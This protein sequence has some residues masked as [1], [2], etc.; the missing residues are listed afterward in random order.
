MGGLLNLFRRSKRLRI[1]V[2][3]ALAL[4]GAVAVAAS[5]LVSGEPADTV[6]EFEEDYE[7]VT[8][9]YGTFER[10]IPVDGGLVF[11]NRQALT[12]EASGVVGDVTVSEGQPVEEG[13]VLATF[14]PLVVAQIEKSVAAQQLNMQA[15]QGQLDALAIP[16][17]VSVAQAE[18]AVV[19]AE[20]RADSAREAIEDLLDAQGV[21]VS[22]AQKK[23]A[24]AKVEVDSAQDAYDD[25][26]DGSFPPEV[27]RDARNRVT[28]AQTNL[29]NASKSLNDAQLLWDN[30]LKR[31]QNNYDDVSE[32]YID[33]FRYW[34]G[35]TP[36]EEE[37]GQEPELLFQDWGLDLDREFSRNN[38]TY[39]GGKPVPDD[40]DTRWN[41]SIIWAWLNIYPGQQSIIGTC[42]DDQLVSGTKRCLER[43][44]ED[45]F[46]VYDE[47]R[48]NWETVQN[49]ATTAIAS[50]QDAV[51]AAEAGLAD[52]Q[53]DLLDV[54]DGPDAS[55]IEDAD[56]RLQLGIASLEQAEDDLL[57]LTAGEDSL[58]VVQA[59]TRLMMAEAS[60]AEAKV[61]L[62]SA[63]ALHERQI[64]VA[65]SDVSLAAAS[66]ED[67]QEDL[68]GAVVR[69]PFNGIVSL[70]NVKVDDA[71]TDDSRVVEVVDPSIIE[72]QG[73]ID[74]ASRQFAQVGSSADVSVQALQGH[75][76]QGAVTFIAP[77][78]RTERGVVT[79]AVR[80]RADVP[81]NVNLPLGLTGVSAVILGE[82][83]NALLVPRDAVS[84]NTGQA[85]VRVM[86]D[87]AV[88]DQPVVLGDT[89]GSWTVVRS[90]L[91]AGDQ[92]VVETDA[93]AAQQGQ[94][95]QMP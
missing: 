56:K 86:R 16:N 71:V 79:Y 62:E 63:R 80:I 55:Q 26:K 75:T 35:V 22:A 4:V 14:D 30:N 2:P 91:T 21:A 76:L 9:R 1:G 3:V 78:P 24:A 36:T 51:T 47:A 59:R 31:A 40:P 77:E 84:R 73:T 44:F 69:A 45:L 61:R 58:E 17:P 38:A 65:Q 18:T 37:L 41:E 88:H 93:L 10:Q 92:V 83:T 74:A 19:E 89:N 53:E 72:V 70:V 5:I 54:E 95:A 8:A 25:I 81:Q 52:A 82:E 29:D 57:E 6:T 60:L 7:V 67:A 34:L 43:E 85:V 28:F 23:V 39:F 15:A 87:G 27:I 46:D 33:L 11:P 94:S 20:V 48:D 50:A 13:Q 42:T 90:G 32:E 68:D 64:Q 66:L 12:F 49:N